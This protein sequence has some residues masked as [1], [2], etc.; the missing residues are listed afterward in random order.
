MDYAMFSKAGNYKVADIVNT[1]KNL[2][3]SEP[4]ERV[5]N[6][7]E[8]ELLNLSNNPKYEEAT[9]TAVREAVYESVVCG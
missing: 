8:A 2:A 4:I 3:V 6:W 9:D 1:A 7:C 5:W